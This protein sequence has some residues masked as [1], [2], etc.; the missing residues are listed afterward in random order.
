MQRVHHKML[1]I[2]SI[3]ERYIAYVMSI[4][5][6]TPNE[7]KL[8]MRDLLRIR[9]CHTRVALKHKKTGLSLEASSEIEFEFI[10]FV[11]CLPLTKL[12]RES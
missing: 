1:F 3:S 10:K 9:I 11:N 2:L 6:A 4:T 12:N 8:R 7:K 5:R